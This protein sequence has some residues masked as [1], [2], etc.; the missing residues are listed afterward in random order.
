MGSCQD[1]PD[2]FRIKQQLWFLSNNNNSRSTGIYLKPCTP[3]LVWVI[4]LQWQQLWFLSTTTISSNSYLS[5]TLF[6]QHW[7]WAVV[8]AR[9]IEIMSLETNVTPGCIL[10]YSDLISEWRGSHNWLVKE[11]KK[12]IITCDR[13][14]DSNPWWKGTNPASLWE[15]IEL[16]WN[17]VLDFA[18]VFIGGMTI[19]IFTTHSSK[20]IIAVTKIIWNPGSIFIFYIYVPWSVCWFIETANYRKPQHSTIH[21]CIW[22]DYPQELCVLYPVWCS[23]DGRLSCRKDY[24]QGHCPS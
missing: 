23:D 18:P 20:F 11:K 24:Q 21:Y 17:I 14:L 5:E 7:Y 16:V 9:K 1:S 2:K 19:A 6:N 10:K 8:A 3:T 4:S 15:N 22:K 13:I 12:V